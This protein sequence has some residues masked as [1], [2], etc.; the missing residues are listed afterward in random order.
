MLVLGAI[1]A[2]EKNTRWG[3]RLSA[4]RALPCSPGPRWWRRWISRC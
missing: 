1:M 4:R 2:S 3:A